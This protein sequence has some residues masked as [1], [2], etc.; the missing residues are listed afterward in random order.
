VRQSGIEWS[1][2]HTMRSSK[3]EGVSGGLFNKKSWCCHEK[4]LCLRGCRSRLR[5][6]TTDIYVAAVN[7]Q[8]QRDYADEI[9]RASSR[10][11]REPDRHEYLGGSRFRSGRS[12]LGWP[13]V[14]A[15]SLRVGPQFWC[16]LLIITVVPEEGVEPTR[17]CDQRILS[18]PRLPFR[19]SGSIRILGYIRNNSNRRAGAPN[20]RMVRNLHLIDR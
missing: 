1:C 3:E 4:L 5:G 6:S 11:H 9:A 18:P 19:H 2:S 20:A 14:R 17:P 15:R 10:H 16:K 13:C 8:F 7:L 12:N